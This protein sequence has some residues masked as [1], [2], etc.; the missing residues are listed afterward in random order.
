MDLYDVAN[1]EVQPTELDRA[2]D[3]AKLRWRHRYENVQMSSGVMDEMR[4]R[5]DDA[6]DAVI[7]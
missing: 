6:G 1:G 4:V 2:E 5:F 3:L 7:L